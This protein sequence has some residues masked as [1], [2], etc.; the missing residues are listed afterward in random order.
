MIS[1]H[2]LKVSGSASEPKQ[3]FYLHVLANRHTK[4][5]LYQGEYTHTETLPSPHRP[6]PKK[7]KK[8]GMT[9]GPKLQSQQTFPKEN[10]MA[11]FS[12]PFHVTGK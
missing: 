2:A 6:P 4:N 3:G 10:T 1:L 5:I 9:Q 12:I 11:N 8:T 7:I